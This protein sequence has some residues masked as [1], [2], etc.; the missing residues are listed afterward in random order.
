MTATYHHGNLEAALLQEAVVQVRE[1][2]ADKVS[3][4]ALA[5]QVGVSPSAAY[6]HFPDKDAL[7]IEVGRVGFD[8]LR[9]R[10]VANVARV[11]GDDD[12]AALAR[13]ETTGRAYLQFAVD[14]PHLFRHMFGPLCRKPPADQ[15]AVGSTAYGLL[16][17]RLTELGERGMLREPPDSTL[18]L[19][20]WSVVHGFAHLAI[21]GQVDPAEGEPLIRR[22]RG[23]LI[24]AHHVPPDE[25][26]PAR[27]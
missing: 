25:D 19:V 2:G 11:E 23:M 16:H 17:Q 5:Q 10:M 20:I 13:L 24:D 6:Q 21:E 26:G 12:A 7:L 4:R 8:R 22:L 14:E 9:E 18:E 15:E 3:L 27:A 1:R